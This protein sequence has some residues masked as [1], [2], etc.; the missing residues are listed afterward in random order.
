MGNL[1]SVKTMQ[2]FCRTELCLT[3]YLIVYIGAFS[4]GQHGVKFSIFVIHGSI[5]DQVSGIICR[6]DF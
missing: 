4:S 5:C 1:E 6:R 3:S 2:Y